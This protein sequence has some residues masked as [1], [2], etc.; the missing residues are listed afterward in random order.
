MFLFFYREIQ[1]FV[2]NIYFIPGTFHKSLSDHINKLSPPVM[3]SENENVDVVQQP[4]AE[5]PKAE[6]PKAEEPKAE[7]PKAEEPKAEE[8]KAEEPKAEEVKAENE[9]VEVVEKPA[10]EEAEKGDEAAAGAEEKAEEDADDQVWVADDAYEQGRVKLEPKNP[11][12]KRPPSFVPSFKVEN[13]EDLQRTVPKK[14]FVVMN[15]FGGN[16]A[17]KK[18]WKKA[19]AVFDE[20]KVEYDLNETQ[21]AG[22][23]TE[24]MQNCDFD[25][26]DA[27]V[28]IGG[29]GYV[30]IMLSCVL[31]QF[32]LHSL[33]YRLVLFLM[34][35]P[36]TT[37]F[38]HS[39][40]S[41]SLPVPL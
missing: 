23:A 25:A 31:L 8:L 18:A 16:G 2:L 30:L 41:L 22:H 12:K 38:R 17:G 20:A 11:K 19:K 10:N 5:E 40:C 15:P 28:I 35:Y 21:H 14:L 6:E 32:F 29:D 33:I 4:K 1:S 9:N 26:Y 3:S 37:C 24:L 34:F 7:E 27:L 36:S 39:H 13:I